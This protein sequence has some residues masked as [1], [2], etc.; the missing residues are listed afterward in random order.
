[1]ENLITVSKK[2]P[3]SFSRKGSDYVN[4]RSLFLIFVDGTFVKSFPNDGTQTE[5]PEI[6]TGVEVL[7]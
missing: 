3:V 4:L 6:I 7:T 5:V 1:M 2:R